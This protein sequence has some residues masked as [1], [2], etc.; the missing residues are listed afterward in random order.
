[1][2]SGI[3]PVLLPAACLP[4]IGF[5]CWLYHAPSVEIEIHE[6]YPKQTCRNRYRI[7]TANGPLILSIPVIKTDGNHTPLARVRIDKSENWNRI[8]WR[9]IESAYNKSPFFLYYKD[10]FERIF[11]NPPELLMD[12]NLTI[13]KI[14]CRFTGIKS[15]FTLSESYQRLPGRPD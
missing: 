9:A 11:H 14:C 5:F 7:A 4:E 1:M 15:E 8:H 10:D 3:P 12:F 6:T 13:L 2:K